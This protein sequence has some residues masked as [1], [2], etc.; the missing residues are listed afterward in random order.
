MNIVGVTGQAGSGK[1]TVADRLVEEHG[2]MKIAL[3][4][5]LKRF[6]HVV[7][8]FT[9]EQLWG[10]SEM[11]NK[12]DKRYDHY[13]RVRVGGV[14]NKST[15]LNLVAG[16]CDPGWW[17]A[18]KVLQNY[19]QEFLD[20][21][22]P[23]G[24]VQQLFDWFT[25]FGSGW[26]RISPRIMLQ[27]LGTEWGRVAANEDIWIDTLVRNASKVLQG[28]PYNKLHGVDVTKQGPPPAGVVVSDVRFKNELQ[29]IK[30]VG[31][32][33]I[34]VSRPE[35]DTD[36][37]TIGIKGHA[38]EMEQKSFEDNDFNVILRNTGSL[39]ELLANVDTVAGTL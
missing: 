10:P 31:G 35:T 28:Y 4:D 38:S 19:A 14:F 39:E 1:D 25:A 30:A 13:C 22:L 15:K 8:G 32:K 18:A 27:H 9:P 29:R 23:E 17:G 6:G 16:E 26:P 5:P 2:Y 36:A 11:R 37:S 21:V 33:L 7:F 34:R 3:A 24:D 12:M 20:E